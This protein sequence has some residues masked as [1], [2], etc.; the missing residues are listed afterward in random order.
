MHIPTAT[1]RVQFGPTLDFKTAYEVVIPYISELGI[2]DIYASPIFKSRKGSSHGYDVVDPTELNP[3]LGNAVDWEHLTSEVKSN[4]LGWLQ[5]IVPNHMAFHRENPFLADILEN[6]PSSR[7][8]DFFDID[9]EHPSPT[10]HGKLLA[11]F[12][13]GFYGDILEKGEIKLFYGQNG[14]EVRYFDLAFPLSMDSYQMVFAHKLGKLK[15]SLGAAHPDYIKLLGALY[16]LKTL[17]VLADDVERYDQIMFVKRTLWELYMEN[18]SVREFYDSQLKL[19]NGT[20]GI[21]DSFKLLH[22]LLANQFFRLTFWKFAKEEIN[23]RRFFN[24]N[25]LISVKVENSKVFDLTHSLILDMVKKGVFTGLRVDH[26]DGLHDPS[27]YLERLREKTGPETYIV[28]EKILAPKEQ[29]PPWPVQGT[30]GYDFLSALNRLMCRPANKRSLTRIYASL[31]GTRKSFEEISREKKQLILEEHMAGD[32]EN[33]AR[34]LKEIANR[35]RHG[36]DITLYGLRRAIKEILAAFPVYRTYVN[37]Q[38]IRKED[39][40]IMETALAEAEKKSPALTHEFSFIRRFLLLEFPDH[41]DENEKME[42]IDITMKFQQFTAP[43]A[44]KGVEDTAFYVY[45]RLISL[46]EVGCT[47]SLLGIRLKDF[48]DLMAARAKKY[49]HSLNSTST[50]DTKRGEDVR[51]RLNILSEIPFEWEKKVKSWM[52]INKDKKTVDKGRA[53]PDINDEYFLYQILI[54]TLP[55]A[56]KPDSEYINRICNY[57]IKAVREAKIHTAWLKPDAE[58]E[59]AFV[60]FFK[61]IITENPVFVESLLSFHNKIAFLGMINSLSQTTLKTTL[62]G[63]PDFYQGTELWDLSL[64]DPDNR[65]P[66]DFKT[67]KKILEKIKKGFSENKYKLIDE[68]KDNW[69][70][71]EIKLFLTWRLLNARAKNKDAFSHGS[72]LPIYA[73]GDKAGHIVA[74]ARCLADKWIITVTTR[75]PAGFIEPNIWPTPATWGKTYLSLPPGAP[76]HMENVLLDQSVKIQQNLL[77]VSELLKTLPSAVLIGKTS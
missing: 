30:T 56:G 75:F 8:F 43:L 39:K 41:I 5:D 15:Q 34:M 40:T 21:S 26:V 2:S 31:T 9:W 13:G 20:P 3:E 61:K 57:L 63:I 12:L 25:D 72:Y 18:P 35:D 16:V 37:G 68:L 52:K 44:A 32:I 17:P 71:G 10:L 59:N 19:F 67:R 47:P 74:F 64:V 24:I 62:P 45:N 33:L 22:E 49:P 36:S 6:G 14:L 53:M 46:N 69:H 11:P 65:R 29:L 76:S 73:S 27:G 7:F 77:D 1:Y 55:P 50:H 51:A 38:G 54:G 4:G 58:Y 66:V 70:T 28:V 42:W 60:T 23:Y 48:H